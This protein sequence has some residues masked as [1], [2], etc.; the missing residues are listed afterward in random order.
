MYIYMYIYI[1]NSD[2]KGDEEGELTFTGGG[3]DTVIDY[4]I[5]DASLKDNIER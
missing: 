1:W 3:E 4:V 5:G 2:T